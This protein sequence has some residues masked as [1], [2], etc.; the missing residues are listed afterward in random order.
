M[1]VVTDSADASAQE[2]IAW[3]R[4]QLLR[5]QRLSTVGTVASGVAHEFN[6]ILTTILNYAKMAQK[7]NVTPESKNQSL[8]KIVAA[9]QR[10]AAIVQGM[11]GM[12]RGSMRR[13]TIDLCKLVDEVLLLAGKDLSKHRVTV[14]KVFSGPVVAEVVPMQIEQVLLNL[15][16]NARQAMPTGGVIRIEVREN[17]ALALAEISVAD[18]GCGMGPEE[19]GHI[20]EPFFTTKTPDSENRGGTGL[21]LSICRQIIDQHRGRIRVQSALGKGS[22][23]TLKLPAHQE[24]VRK[25]A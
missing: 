4:D 2:E 9:S 15:L 17:P 3:L 6:N 11:L 25:A 7:P 1:R 13:E 12:A 21:G 23:F 22:I 8:E 16:I 24:S 10:A 20:F 14:E 19:L 5:S 18:S